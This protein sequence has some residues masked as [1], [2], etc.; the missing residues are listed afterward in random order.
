MRE[1]GLYERLSSHS[2]LQGHD[3]GGATLVFFVQAI[4][5]VVLQQSAQDLP[6]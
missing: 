4:T 2:V 1:R 6:P 5:L 3:G